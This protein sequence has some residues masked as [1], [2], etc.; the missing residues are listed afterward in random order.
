MIC[1][2][3]VLSSV[4]TNLG[5]IL[6]LLMEKRT[7]LRILSFKRRYHKPILIAFLLINF[8][9][10]D[11]LRSIHMKECACSF[12]KGLNIYYLPNMCQAVG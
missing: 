2:V 3:N 7:Q 8:E 12:G 11:E 5:T 1:H 6:K 9:A 4:I 10:L